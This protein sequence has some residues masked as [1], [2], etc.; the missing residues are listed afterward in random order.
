MTQMHRSRF[1]AHRERSRSP[2]AA[3]WITSRSA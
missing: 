1:F 3:L 2:V